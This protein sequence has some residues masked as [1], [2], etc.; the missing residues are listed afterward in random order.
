MYNFNRNWDGSMSLAL[1]LEFS[2]MAN[3]V[4]LSKIGHQRWEKSI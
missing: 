2:G 3:I 4:A 1:I